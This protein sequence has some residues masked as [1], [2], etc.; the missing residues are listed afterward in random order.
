MSTA[1]ARLSRYKHA[2]VRQTHF[3][4]KNILYK[5]PNANINVFNQSFNQSICRNKQV[6]RDSS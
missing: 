3:M 5:C 6:E 1:V 2:S 4:L